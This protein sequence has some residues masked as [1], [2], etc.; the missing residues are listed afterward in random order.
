M[1][2]QSF[3]P[4]EIGRMHGEEPPPTVPRLANNSAAYREA[5]AAE[6]KAT[7]VFHSAAE[8]VARTPS[9]PPWLV[10]GYVARGAIT[11]VVGKV[12]AAG[13]TT[14]ALA[15]CRAIIRGEQFAGLATER[16]GVVYLTEQPDASFREGLSRAGLSDVE[17]FRT[18]PWYAAVG[19]P[20]EVVVEQSVVECSRSGAGLLVVDTLPQWAGIRG[21]GENNAGE[22]LRAVVPLQV[23]A[24][25]HGLAVLSIRHSRKS[26]GD[27]GDDGRGSSAF[28]GTADIVLSL[29]RPEGQAEP[30]IRVLHGLSRFSDTP[31]SFVLKLTPDG[32]E[33]LG[34]ET[35]LAIEAA[36]SRLLDL[37]PVSAENA[38]T[39]DE[40]LHRAQVKRTSGQAA[41]GALRET[42]RLARLG[43]GK[44]GSPYRYWAPQSFLPDAHP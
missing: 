42:G 30:N 16:T 22:A 35:A 34:D 39:S 5:H 8:L 10:P 7:L 27:V 25:V 9:A 19:V 40:L 28:A 14:L 11:E 44:R 37:A 2:D 4:D 26:G 24:G 41:I 13:K 6:T 38:L 32:Y 29:R 36:K 18:L 20:W 17:E 43:D 23:A 12:K 33:A 3:D 21:D 31:D 1:S 15:M